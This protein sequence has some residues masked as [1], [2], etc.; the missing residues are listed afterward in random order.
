MARWLT[1]RGGAAEAAAADAHAA[2]LQ[3]AG[4]PHGQ[5]G[6]TRCLHGSSRHILQ[7][8]PRNTLRG[9]PHTA[10]YQAVTRYVIFVNC[11]LQM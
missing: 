2:A 5:D 9:T 8:F 4:A 1:A 7:N 3:V 10:E 11:G 6:A